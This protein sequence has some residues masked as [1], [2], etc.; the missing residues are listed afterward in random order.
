MDSFDC[1]SIIHFG[2]AGAVFKELRIGDLVLGEEIVEYENLV[3][4]TI[5]EN[6][7]CL[8]LE[9]AFEQHFQN[10]G[11]LFRLKLDNLADNQ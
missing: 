5:Y 1:S 3:S 7:R 6:R 4:R 8:I 10:T 11:E 2:S 9:L